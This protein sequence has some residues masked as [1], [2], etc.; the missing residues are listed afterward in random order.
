MKKL[1][2]IISIIFFS[3]FVI[4]EIGVVYASNITTDKTVETN[5]NFK[6]IE[7][8][9]NCLNF[10]ITDSKKQELTDFNLKVKLNNFK[11]V[12]TFKKSFVDITDNEFVISKYLKNV[13]Q[14]VPS[15]LQS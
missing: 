15:A 7:D 13:F 14:I 4:S 11:G 8:T 9:S 12:D 5:V 3:I 1:C 10:E 6:L 2:L